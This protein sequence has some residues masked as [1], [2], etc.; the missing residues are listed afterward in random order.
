M[1]SL[2]RPEAKNALSNSLLDSFGAV[3]KDINNSENSTKIRAVV[4]RSLVDGVFC[5]GADL[6]VLKISVD[7]LGTSN[8]D[9]PASN[10]VSVKASSYISHA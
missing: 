10:A 2:N 8:N 1:V 9:S 5:A 4:V 3:L 7:L 6:K